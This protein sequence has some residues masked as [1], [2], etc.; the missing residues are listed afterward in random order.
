M[1]EIKF[2]VWDNHIAEMFYDIGIIDNELWINIDSRGYDMVGDYTED[3]FHIMQYTGLKDKNGKE[4]Y[5]GDILTSTD[6][7]FQNYGSHNYYGVIEW[8]NE[9]AAFCITK[10]LAPSSKSRGISDGISEHLEDIE[11]FEIIGNIY[12]NPELLEESK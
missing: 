6:Y 7:P 8:W 5:E 1:R 4:I 2:R 11:R 9:L 10:R 3:C 12:E